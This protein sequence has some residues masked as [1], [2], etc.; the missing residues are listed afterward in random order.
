[1]PKQKKPPRRFTMTPEQERMYCQIWLID[2]EHLVLKLK[3]DSTEDFHVSFCYSHI[4]WK[5]K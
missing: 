1:M 5:K 4:G 2:T 3:G